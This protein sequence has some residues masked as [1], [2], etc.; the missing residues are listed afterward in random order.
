MNRTFPLL[1]LIALLSGCEQ[2]A[3]L[4]PEVRFETLDVRDISFDDIEADFVFQVENPNPVEVGLDR[5][6]YD[7][8]LEAISLLSGDQPEGLNLPAAAGAEVRLPARLVWTEVWDT[9]QAIRGEDQVDFGLDGSFGFDTDWGPLDLPYQTEGR[10][11]ALRTPKFRL[12][13]LRVTGVDLLRGRAT[14]NLALAVDNDHGS[15]LTFRDMDYKV[16]LRGREVATGLIP[17]LG[18]VDGASEKTVDVPVTVDLLKAGGA[19]VDILTAGGKLEAGID[20]TTQV[21][22]PFGILPLSIDETG[23]VT[24]QR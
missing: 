18:A 17:E 3:A 11:P 5:F 15:T 12:G 9:V 1:P 22:T 6:S 20:A 2:L 14:A 4:V 19:V 13:N 16:S 10:F 8:Q 23:D 24:V 21:D 7:L